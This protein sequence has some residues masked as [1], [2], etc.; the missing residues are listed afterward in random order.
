MKSKFKIAT[1]V[2]GIVVLGF[3]TASILRAQTKPPAYTFVEIDVKDQDGYTKDYLPK[4][5]AHIKEFGGK[6]LGGGFNNAVGLSGAPPANRVVLLQFPDMDS[7]KA[8]S[9]KDSPDQK[10]V[11]SKY[12]SFHTMAFPGVEP[13]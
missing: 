8:F 5:Q 9:D 1:A 12:A 6:Y 3:G 11:G 10:D 4:V 7:A 13:K 2:T